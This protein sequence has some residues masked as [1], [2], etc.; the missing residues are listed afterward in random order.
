MKDNLVYKYITLSKHKRYIQT[1]LL[2][3]SS[4]FEEYHINPGGKEEFM[5]KVIDAYIIVTLHNWNNMF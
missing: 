3:D 4:Q 1:K 2:S 5:L